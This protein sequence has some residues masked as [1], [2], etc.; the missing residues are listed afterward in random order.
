MRYLITGGAGFIGSNLA[1]YYSSAGHDV[2]VVDNL[3][4]G[5]IQNLLSGIKVYKKDITDYEFMK[6]ILKKG[7]FDY[8]FH[9]AAVASV[10]D[11][12]SRPIETHKINNESVIMLLEL[13]KSHAKNLK[14][15][16]FASSAA[17]YGNELTLPKS[18][19]SIIRPLSPYAIDKFSSEVFTTMYCELYNVPTS[20]VRFFNVYGPNQNPTSPY[21]GVISLLNDSFNRNP[22]NS[23]IDFTVFGNGK[24]TRDFIY[25]KDVVSALE[26]IATSAFS[27]GEV[28]NV[29]TGSSNSLNE[30]I[31]IMSKIYKRK[32][33]IQYLPSRPGDITHSVSSI[34][35]LKKLGFIPE[36]DLEKGLSCYI[37]NEI[38]KENLL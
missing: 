12:I 5:K 20:C 4:T 38:D 32:I 10:A 24:Q 28:Y 35:K 36:Y 33:K 9:L 17:V 3:S 30:V 15:F 1:N 19:K 8:I 26:K 7:K 13:I 16:V 22:A 11:S 2:V 18:E 6:N 23:E 14:R 29:G 21:S 31:E 25:V 27:K 34:D 37:K